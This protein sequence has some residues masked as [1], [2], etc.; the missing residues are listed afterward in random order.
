MNTATGAKRPDDTGMWTDAL[1]GFSEEQLR[2][3]A[4]SLPQIAWTGL[5]NGYI[6]FMNGRWFD[7]TGLTP[8]ETYEELKTAVHPDDVLRYRATWEHAVKTQE[9][10]EVEYRFRRASDGMYRWHLGR[11]MVVRNKEGKVTKWFGTCTDIHAQKMAEEEMR[12]LNEKLETLVKERTGHLQL[13]IERRRATEAQHLEH[14]LLL[15]RMINT[16][17]FAAAAVS[18]TDVLLHLNE[19]FRLLFTP[20]AMG[21]PLENSSALV[22]LQAAKAFYVSSDWDLFFEHMKK[23]SAFGHEIASGDGR[24]F[25]CEY[26][27]SSGEAGGYLLLVR[28]ITQEKRVDSVKSEFMSLASHQLRTPLTSI[29]WALGRFSRTMADRLTPEELRL[30]GVM[31]ESASAM[32]DTIRTMLSISRVEAGLHAATP[33][34]FYVRKFLQ[35]FEEV[36]AEAARIKKID[37]TVECHKDIKLTTDRLILREILEN[38][39]SNAIK[40]TNEGGSV[41]VKVWQDQDAVHI[42]VEDTGVGIPEHQ[43]EKIFSKF[44]RAE[45]ILLMDMQG[46][47]LGLY[48]VSR[49]VAVLRGSINFTSVLNKGTCF[50]LTLPADTAKN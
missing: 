7:Y 19:S 4:E 21:I 8:K 14:L 29:R 25:F 38:L 5:P 16:L 3:L 12:Q 45:N 39:L 23:G 50:V 26:V 27:P 32:S 18:S 28:D 10:Y 46:T 22:F 24:T 48:L 35:L 43:H 17:P 40:Y 44:F 9:P 20:L 33:T 6:D 15:Q 2:F 47:G 41:S 42:A 31:R 1:V 30:L 34:E 13:E 36:F 37:F 49:L 11:G